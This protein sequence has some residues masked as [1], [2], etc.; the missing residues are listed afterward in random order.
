V[1]AL[2][3]HTLDKYKDS[4]QNDSLSLYTRVYFDMIARLVRSHT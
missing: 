4:S 3:S 1:E 2:Q